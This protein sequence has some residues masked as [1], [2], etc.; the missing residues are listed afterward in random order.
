MDGLTELERQILEFE[1]R[2]WKLPGGKE[3]AIRETF[4]MSATRYYQII[5]HLI[6]DERAL[7][8]FPVLVNR[9]RRMPSTRWRA[10]WSR[11]MVAEMEALRDL[12]M[13]GR[14]T[15]TEY[16]AA[17][18]RIVEAHKV[19]NDAIESDGVL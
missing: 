4:D 18:A 7:A 19:V 3:T 12:R 2:A 15:D 10:A 17:R 16:D 13:T 6:R 9:L 11:Q 5:S 8:E 14:I 1:S